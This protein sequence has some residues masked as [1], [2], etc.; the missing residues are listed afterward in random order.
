MSASVSV[1]NS[2][3]HEAPV[4]SNAES[5]GRRV[6]GARARLANGRDVAEVACAQQTMTLPKVSRPHRYMCRLYWRAVWYDE[7]GGGGCELPASASPS[8]SR[9][10]RYIALFVEGGKKREERGLYG[11]RGLTKGV[12]E[13]EL[14]AGSVSC[15]HT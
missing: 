2:G 1:C 6:E 14:A 3:S 7:R 10:C 5:V 8:G 4:R 13:S 11:K 12:I 15:L 9:S